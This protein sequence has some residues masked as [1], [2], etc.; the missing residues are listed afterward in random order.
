[1]ADGAADQGTSC[2]GGA[3]WA[4]QEPGPLAGV[5]VVT[6]EQTVARSPLASSPILAPGSS[7]SS[8]R[9]EVTSAVITTAPLGT[10]C[11]AG[12]SGSTGPRSQLP[13]TSR[14]ITGTGRWR[15]SSAGPT[16]SSA[17]SR[18]RPSRA[19]AWT[20]R[21]CTPATPGWSP[22]RSAATGTTARFLVAARADRAGGGS[23]YR[24]SARSPSGCRTRC[25]S[26]GSPESRLLAAAPGT[27]A[28]FLTGLTG[29]PTG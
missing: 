21:T 10:A 29:P 23:E 19:W 22:V 13:W 12:S 17:T 4:G 15:N 14:P 20:R 26:P 16:Y 18:R 1:M 3:S 7:R 25:Y 9:E 11:P 24:C 8:G 28:S 5:L 6:L 2:T 27:R